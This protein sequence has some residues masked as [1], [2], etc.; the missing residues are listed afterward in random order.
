M[1]SEFSFFCTL[2]LGVG[3]CGGRAS[4]SSGVSLELLGS[5]SSSSLEGTKARENRGRGLQ[6]TRSRASILSNRT[7]I[8]L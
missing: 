1:F 8:G 6:Q 4:E 7:I 3:K 2:F 5:A